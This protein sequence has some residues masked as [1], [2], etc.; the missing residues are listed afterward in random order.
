MK[1]RTVLGGFGA[2]AAA[3]TVGAVAWDRAGRLPIH[4]PL[5]TGDWANWSH[6]QRCH[7]KAIETPANLEELRSLITGST[8]TIRPVGSGHSFSALVPTD[9]T[10]VRLDQFA[11]IR[12]VDLKRKTAWVGAGA[13]L[14]DLSPALETEG[15]AF[16]NLGDINVQSLAGAIGTGTHGTGAAL[17]SL[18]AEVV[19]VRLMTA[20]GDV[21][22]KSLADDP[23]FVHAAQVSLGALGIL[24][25]VQVQLRDRFRLHRKTWVEPTRDVIA[26]APELWA[27]HHNFEFLHIPFSGHSFCIAHD[28]TDA[29]ETPRAPNT[30]DQTM[31]ELRRLFALTRWNEG[32]RRKLVGDAIAKGQTEDVVGESWRLLA[33]PRN[34][35]FNE[36]EYH[37]PPDKALGAMAEVIETLENKHPDVYFPIECRMTAGDEGWLSPFNGGPRISVAAHVYYADDHRLLF[38]DVEPIH[39]RAGGRPHWGK[40]HRP[41]RERLRA[42]YPDFD[43]F[44][45]LRGKLDPQGRF[46]NSFLTSLF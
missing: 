32:L 40:L 11:D 9:G 33:T 23:D 26:K 3:G 17:R 10:I 16:K 5:P 25:D 21:I 8:G 36:M 18:A 27:R 35:Y 19:G 37:L 38:D 20:Q 28:E 6:N 44:A 22:E 31:M 12:S 46:L 15:L 30:D 34:V 29:P 24:T 41:Q 1:R 14:R 45:A 2:V 43:R 4:D 13:K 39:L 7:P 42:L